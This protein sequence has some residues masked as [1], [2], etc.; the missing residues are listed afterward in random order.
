MSKTIELIKILRDRTGAGLMDCK[1]ALLENND[2]VEAAISWL[3]ENGIA[4]VAKKS[5]R[6]A[7]E[8]LTNVKV[9]GN[10]AVVLE[11][12]CETDFVAHSDA[13]VALIDDCS[14][15][16]LNE[17]PQC[18]NC[19]K[20]AKLSNGNT[21]EQ[22]FTDATIKLGEKL[23]LR[24]F[25]IVE[26]TDSQIF[27]SYIHLKGKISVLVK[28]EG[29]NE[30]LARGIAMTVAS[31]NPQYLTEADIPADVMQKEFE[32]QKASSLLD[33][34]FGKKPANI[35]ESI[36][37]GKVNKV[38]AE[39]I[40]V[41]QEYVLDTTKT[42]SQVLAENKAKVLAFVRYQVGEG[43]EKRVDDF[44]SEVMSQVN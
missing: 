7:A 14:T 12:N 6:I 29:G 22:A 38:F 21:I 2:D 37:N 9:E 5:G 8:G 34:S 27:A 25:E 4:K 10:K 16:I 11:I 39:Q 42:V 13:F 40:L 35:Q 41:K 15:A 26:K 20:S 36:I 18:I 32:I 43:L 24:R 1:K 28:M 17:K 3:R 23:D 44:A 31:S 30:E 19:A 33:E